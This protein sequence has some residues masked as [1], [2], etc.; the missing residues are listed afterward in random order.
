MALNAVLAQWTS[1]ERETVWGRSY[2]EH[3]RAIADGRGGPWQESDV[4]EA[5]RLATRMLAIPVHAPELVP[6][7]GVRGTELAGLLA[8]ALALVELCERTVQRLSSVART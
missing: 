1:D 6:L 8:D 7:G 4:D 3:L 2:L 5:R